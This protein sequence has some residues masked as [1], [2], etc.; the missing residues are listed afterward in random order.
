MEPEVKKIWLSKTFWT[1]V[2]LAAAIPFLPAEMQKPEYVAYL[3]AGVNFGLR[4]ISKGK[5]ELW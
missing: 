2:V 3:M 4:L 1:N 5:V